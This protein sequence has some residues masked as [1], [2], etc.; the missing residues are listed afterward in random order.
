MSSNSEGIKKNYSKVGNQNLATVGAPGEMHGCKNIQLE[1]GRVLS[2]GF[3]AEITMKK[4]SIPLVSIVLD[5]RFALPR[6]LLTCAN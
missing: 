6:E 1:I 5:N 3:S 2:A 4:V